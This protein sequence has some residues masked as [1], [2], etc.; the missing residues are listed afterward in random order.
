M[1]GE[2]FRKE[3]PILTGLKFGFGSGSSD[4][5]AAGPVF[6]GSGGNID[7]QPG[8]N[9]Y[10]YH[11]FTGP[12]TLTADSPG[13]VEVLLVAG[14]GTGGATDNSNGAGGGGAGGIVHHTDLSVTGPLTIT[15]GAKKV[16]PNSINSVGVTGNDSTIVS[17]TGP[18][19]LTAK[20]GGGGGHYGEAGLDGGSGG[21]GGGFGENYGNTHAVGIQTTQNPAFTSQS[22]FNQYG[23]AGG[24]PSDENPGNAGG[25]GGAGSVGGSSPE[26]EGG[27]AVSGGGAGQPFTGF[28]GPIPAFA[29]LPTAWKNAV[30][31]TGLFGGGGGGENPYQGSPTGAPGPGGGGGGSGISPPVSSPG[32]DNTGGGG[33]GGALGPQAGDGGAGICIVRYQ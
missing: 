4:A 6:S 28:A 1:F 33:A 10:T 19:T 7:G 13:P 20:G 22:G 29:P 30:G 21:G 12:G 23:N 8:G 5:A 27:P 9:G 26:A 11:V 14:G 24:S 32:I 3:S 31:P 16:Y 2:L 17:P 18:W 15:V 25:G